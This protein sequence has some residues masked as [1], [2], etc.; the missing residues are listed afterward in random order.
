MCV[1]GDLKC[2]SFD[3]ATTIGY[4]ALSYAWGDPFRTHHILC[5]DAGWGTVSFAKIAITANLADWFRHCEV[6]HYV[7]W[8]DAISSRQV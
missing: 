7:L 2:H 1:V 5:F 4:T 3:E 6:E 8:I